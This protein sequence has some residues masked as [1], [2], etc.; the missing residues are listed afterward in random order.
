MIVDSSALIAMLLKEPDH[1]LL[2]Q[3]L[4]EADRICVGAPTLVETAIVLCAR[5]GPRGKTLLARFVHEAGLDVVEFTAEHWTAAA[6]AYISYGKGRHPAALNF[7]DCLAYAVSAV[8]GEPL[9]CKGDDFPRTD[10]ALVS[11]EMP[12][13][14]ESARPDAE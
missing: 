3:R 11:P 10:L 2:L 4:T 13:L 6:D 7:G 9:L 5:L 14:D 12:S 1:E 8:A